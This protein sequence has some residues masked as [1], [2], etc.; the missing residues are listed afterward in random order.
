MK[1]R[2]KY[3]TVLAYSNLPEMLVSS[4]PTLHPFPSMAGKV[5]FDRGSMFLG[6]P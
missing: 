2:V 6:F 1:Q 4:L 5:K 3:F